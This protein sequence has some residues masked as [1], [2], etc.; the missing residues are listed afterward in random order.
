MEKD[1]V[2]IDQVGLG[3]NDFKRGKVQELQDKT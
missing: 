3:L 1:E 2:F